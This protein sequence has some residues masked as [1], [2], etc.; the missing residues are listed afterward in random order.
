MTRATLLVLFCA[1]FAINVGAFGAAAY[2]NYSHPEVANVDPAQHGGGP[3]QLETDLGLSDEQQAAFEL[4]REEASGHIDRASAQLRARRQEL[5]DLLTGPSPDRAAI[6]R[7]VSD[8]SAEQLTIQRA[9]VNQWIQQQDVL[10]GTQRAEFVRLLGERLVRDEHQDAEMGEELHR[11]GG[12][13]DDRR[14]GPQGQGAPLAACTVAALSKSRSSVVRAVPGLSPSGPHSSCLYALLV[15]SEVAL[16]DGRDEMLD[17]AVRLRC[18]LA[19]A[20]H[21]LPRH[22]LMTSR[23]VGGSGVSASPHRHAAS[24]SF[25]NRACSL[26]MASP[27]RRRA[28]CTMPI[29]HYWPTMTWGRRCCAWWTRP[30]SAR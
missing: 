12:H 21:E 17:L 19:H 3:Q 30:A 6:D 22:A 23:R 27:L 20:V 25:F 9:V 1:S 5:F 24:C 29:C 10:T 13:E 14:G 11:E 7:T 4:A 26:S 16:R 8:I 2:R 28:V 15:F 18:Q